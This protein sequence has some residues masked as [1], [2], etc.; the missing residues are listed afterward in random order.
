MTTA[1]KA[2]HNGASP[3]KR[4]SERNGGRAR[5]PGEQLGDLWPFARK[6]PQMLQARMKSHPAAVVAGVGATAFVL[7]ALCGSKVGRLVVTTLADY[8]L[9]RLLEGPLAREVTRFATDAVRRANDTA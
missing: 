6:L 1:D 9:R 2:G 3:H 7:G 5:S 4:A 8:G